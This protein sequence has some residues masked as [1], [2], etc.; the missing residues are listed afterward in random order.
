VCSRPENARGCAQIAPC[1]AEMSNLS[2]TEDAHQTRAMPILR[3]SFII[4]SSS[5]C[6]AVS[7]GIATYLAGSTRH[8]P[9]L[10]IP[11]VA[12]RS[13]MLSHFALSAFRIAFVLS[14]KAQ[15]RNVASKGSKMITAQMRGCRRGRAVSAGARVAIAI[16]NVRFCKTALVGDNKSKRKERQACS[17]N[18]Q[19]EQLAKN[20]K[21]AGRNESEHW[22]KGRCDKCPLLF[23]PVTC[24]SA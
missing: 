23:C 18:A 13:E 5:I 2:H 17:F 19:K 15:P 4:T 9:S 6:S 24:G 20:A 12:I 21:S 10:I 3:I 14:L 1:H 7:L 16:A 8:Q 22:Q 11:C